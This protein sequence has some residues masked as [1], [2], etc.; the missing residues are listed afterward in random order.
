MVFH[1]FSSLFYTGH[2][3]L[4]FSE[5]QHHVHTLYVPLLSLPWLGCQHGARLTYP[6]SWLATS[7]GLASILEVRY[8]SL[9]LF[10]VF[11]L[12]FV[13]VS[14]PPSSACVWYSILY[15]SLSPLHMSMCIYTT[16]VL[17]M[18][19]ADKSLFQGLTHLHH[20]Y[21]AVW[22]ISF[23]FCELNVIQWWS[24][25]VIHLLCLMELW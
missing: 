15:V 22:C 8:F 2:F 1:A 9:S 14:L 6:R 10:E 13:L 17:T 7:T 11:H 23:H 5:L 20:R 25:C 4:V 21:I 3:C 19:D 24:H 12:L 18:T 16:C